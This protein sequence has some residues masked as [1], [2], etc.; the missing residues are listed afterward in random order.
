[1]DIFSLAIALADKEQ[2]RE[3][4]VNKQE[5]TAEEE[6]QRAA[7]QAALFGEASARYNTGP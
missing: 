3:K 7:E 1:M 4:R 2:N 6:A 5:F